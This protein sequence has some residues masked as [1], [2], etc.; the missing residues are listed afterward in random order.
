[1]AFA[2]GAAVKA[3]SNLFFVFQRPIGIAA[4]A[5]GARVQCDAPPGDAFLRRRHGRPVLHLAESS[6]ATFA[7]FIALAG[8]AD[9]DAWRVGGR[10]VPDEPGRQRIGGKACFVG[11]ILMMKNHQRIDLGQRTHLGRQRQAVRRGTPAA[12]VVDGRFDVGDMQGWH[13]KSVKCP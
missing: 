13:G 12:P 1:M 10:L 8:R 6:A 9:R 5:P 11:Q 7:Q 4:E 2:P 3:G